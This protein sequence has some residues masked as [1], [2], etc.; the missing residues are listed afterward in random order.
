MSGEFILFN[1][2]LTTTEYMGT[3]PMSFLAL[4]MV[5]DPNDTPVFMGLFKGAILPGDIITFATGFTA[6][7]NAAPG[8]YT[9]KV[10]IWNE[11]P[12]VAGPN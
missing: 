7:V 9:V 6:P 3:E 5:K 11:W 2:E 4:V 10:F 8:N 1:V 12:S